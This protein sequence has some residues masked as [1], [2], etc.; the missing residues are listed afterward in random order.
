MRNMSKETCLYEKKSEKETCLREKTLWKIRIWGVRN[1]AKETYTNQK[2][3]AKIK[4]TL[5]IANCGR[6]TPESCGTCQKRP[7]YIKMCEIWA[8]SDQYLHPKKR[9]I[10][11]EKKLIMY[12]LN[13]IQ[14]R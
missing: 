5:N 10:F 11:T 2:R 6:C 13:Q 3:P 1:M 7:I 12:I 14:N 4:R 9:Y 8:K